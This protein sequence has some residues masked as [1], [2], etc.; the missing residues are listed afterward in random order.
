[1]RKMKAEAN[2][3]LKSPEGVAYRKQRPADIE[4]VFGKGS[5]QP[6]QARLGR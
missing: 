5:R 4:P 3:K 1:L 2:A 6:G